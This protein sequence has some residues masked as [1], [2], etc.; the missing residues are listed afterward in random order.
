MITALAVAAPMPLL[1]LQAASA[2]VARQGVQHVAWTALGPALAPAVA[3]LVL[4]AVDAVVGPRRGGGWWRDAVAMTGLLAGLLLVAPLGGEARATFCASPSSGEGVSAN[5]ACGYVASPLTLALQVL[6]LS[7]AVICL[8]LAVGQRH[9][10]TGG[11]SGAPRTEHHLLLLATTAGACVLAGARDYATLA[12]AFETA[13]LPVIGLVAL[14]RDGRGAEAGLKLLLTAV[15]SFALLVLGIALVYASTGSLHLAAPVSAALPDLDLLHG[16]G[17]ALAV[18]GIA[19]KLSLVP[20]HAWTPDT[21]AGAP[22]PIA[23]FLATVSKVAGLTAIVLVLGVGAPD[24]GPSWSRLAGALAAVTMTVGNLV[25]LRQRTA[26]RLLAWSTVAQAGWVVLPLA[27]AVT[28][29]RVP[30]AATASIGYLLAYVVATL[31]AFAVVV[32]LAQ[33]HPDGDRHPLAAY[34]GLLRTR[35]ALAAVLGFALLCLAGLPPG[36]MGL[37]AKVVALG[38]VVAAHAWVLTAVAVLNVV[39]GVAVYLRWGARLVASVPDV[40]PSAEPATARQPVG[41]ATP[42]DDVSWVPNPAGAAGGSL[43]GGTATSERALGA[44]VRTA[45]SVPHGVA[46]LLGIAGCVVLSL[47]PAL[48]ANP[49]G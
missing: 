42:S 23:A 10:P 21:Y 43:P 12:V 24:L 22:A 8:L 48:V 29:H 32:V 31:T 40:E 46:L 1:A 9:A 2:D 25:A 38:P 33:T 20:F 26:V 5:V 6:V 37:V 19:F 16:V 35:P 39:L 17:L 27:G 18:A 13:S 41:G 15:L 4:L 28:P 30:A 47:L 44:D 36:V 14:R 49:L 3:A 45:I 7:A 34:D 11:S